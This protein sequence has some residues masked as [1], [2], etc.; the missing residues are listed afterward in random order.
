ME[1]VPSGEPKMSGRLILDPEWLERIVTGSV[2]LPRFSPG[3]PAEQ[4]QTAL[5][6][7]DLILPENTMEQLREVLV[8]IQHKDAI[9]SY[10]IL[11]KHLKPGFRVLFHGPPGTGKTLTANLLGKVTGRPVFRVDLSMVVSKY[12]GETEK[13]LAA[14]FDKA[15]P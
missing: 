5:E 10:E 7:D 15:A 8:W 9:S 13:N 1:T 11:Q 12:I 3:F 4:L 6:W 2:S 14:L